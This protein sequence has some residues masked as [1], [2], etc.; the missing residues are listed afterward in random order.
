M[1]QTAT[2]ETAT[3]HNNGTRARPGRRKS[4]TAPNETSAQRFNR[5][6]NQRLGELLFRANQIA[7]L[8]R[9]NYEYTEAQRDPLL[10]ECRKGVAGIE[11]AFA[12]K[13]RPKVQRGA[14]RLF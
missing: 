11:A 13:A 1:T 2:T 7:Q 9:G 5:L 3:T 4:T 10:A 12:D 8:A 14:Y 6:C